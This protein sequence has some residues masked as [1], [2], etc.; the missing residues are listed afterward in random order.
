MQCVWPQGQDTPT[1]IQWASFQQNLL[2]S[3]LSPIFQV[4]KHKVGAVIQLGSAE[5]GV[6][7]FGPGVSAFCLCFRYFLVVLLVTD[8]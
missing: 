5:P 2:V 1:Q 6:A 7:G 8:T 3:V 4:E